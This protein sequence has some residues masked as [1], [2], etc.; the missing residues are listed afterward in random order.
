MHT[1]ETELKALLSEH[2]LG[3]ILGSR[4][5]IGKILALQSKAIR[6]L[7]ANGE[8]IAP[9]YAALQQMLKDLHGLQAKCEQLKDSPYPRQYA[10]INNIFVWTFCFML[11]FGIV[12]DFDLLN[13]V[14]DAPLR[15]YMAWVTIPF[16]M[17]I[18]WMY[19]SLEQV[20]ESTENPFE[21]SA[22]DVPISQI[23]QQ[24]NI[25]LREMLGETSLPD[26]L[27]P[28]NNIIL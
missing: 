20:G 28:H 8:V 9:Q 2:E 3:L 26:D 6:S 1:V 21:G 22:N 18:S 16:S 12:H 17:L 11:P 7:N 15:G 4:N 5:R 24:L 19:I 25:E 14:V 10:V 27:Q 13:E 23:S